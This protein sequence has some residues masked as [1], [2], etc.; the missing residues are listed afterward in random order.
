MFIQIAYAYLRCYSRKRAS[1]LCAKVICEKEYDM[2]L[3]NDFKE[4]KEV[5]KNLKEEFNKVKKGKK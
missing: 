1:I 4:A 3:L 2:G 5:A